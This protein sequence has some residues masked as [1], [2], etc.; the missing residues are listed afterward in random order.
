M[1][2]IRLILFDLYPHYLHPCLFSKL[3][4]EALQKLVL[5]DIYLSRLYLSEPISEFVEKALYKLAKFPRDSIRR[6]PI[7]L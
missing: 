3:V 7:R 1:E 4:D 6:W 2:E 5:F